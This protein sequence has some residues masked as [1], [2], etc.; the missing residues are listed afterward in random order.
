M[1][2]TPDMFGGKPPRAAPRVLMHVCD[3]GDGEADKP[4]VR[5]SCAKC[6][7]ETDW[8]QCDTV[9]EAKAGMAC[10]NCNANQPCA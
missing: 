6:G 3:A 8:V 10:P 2:R 5:F 4:I 7:H 9:T 1:S